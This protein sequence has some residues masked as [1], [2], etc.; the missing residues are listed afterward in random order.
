MK[1]SVSN[2]AYL[3]DAVFELLVRE[4]LLS[5]G[6]R[7]V[8]TLN[9][10]ALQYVTAKAQAK[11]YHIIAPYLTEAEESTLRRGRNLHSNSKAKN[12]DISEYRHATGLE[13]LFGYLYTTG[14][15]ER[16]AEIF[17]I[18]TKED[19]EPHNEEI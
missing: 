6:S 16:L 19:E 1:Q 13:T 7:P 5:T 11:M 10:E 14:Q 17:A 2:L 15:K 4:M 18:C 12:A 8:S 3:G 9:Q